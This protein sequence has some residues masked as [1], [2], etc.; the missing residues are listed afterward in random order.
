MKNPHRTKNFVDP[1]EDLLYRRKFDSMIV[2]GPE[3]EN[4]ILPDRIPSPE[5]LGLPCLEIEVED[6]D[7][8]DEGRE[9]V[10][11]VLGLI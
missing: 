11:L 4:R 1:T 6:G 8:I 10:A 2:I 5:Q 9:A 3:A 7:A